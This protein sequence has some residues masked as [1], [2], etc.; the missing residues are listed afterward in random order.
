[1]R[2]STKAA[3]M[4]CLRK[5]RYPNELAATRAATAMQRKYGRKFFTIRCPVGMV[6]EPRHWHIG[7]RNKTL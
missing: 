7:R 5:Q 2:H 1:M 3:K 6:G 4:Q